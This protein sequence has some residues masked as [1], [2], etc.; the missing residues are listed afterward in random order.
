MAGNSKGG[1]VNT[2]QFCELKKGIDMLIQ[3]DNQLGLGI[4]ILRR[5]ARKLDGK[6]GTVENN[7]KLLEERVGSI[8]NAIKGLKQNITTTVGVTTGILGLV[9]FLIGYAK[10][11]DEGKSPVGNAHASQ[12]QQQIVDYNATY[13]KQLDIISRQLGVLEK[14]SGKTEAYK[15]EVKK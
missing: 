9:G 3:N 10:G 4:K 5:K 8:N 2:E 6:V 14:I 13:N 12:Y 7:Y 1:K 11:C 15:E